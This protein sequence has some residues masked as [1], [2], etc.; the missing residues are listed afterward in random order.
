MFSGFLLCVAK[1]AVGIC[2]ELRFKKAVSVINR[3]SK[4]I[5]KDRLV[6]GVGL[7]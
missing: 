7:R 1:R 4:N 6:K 5:T 2:G 3:T